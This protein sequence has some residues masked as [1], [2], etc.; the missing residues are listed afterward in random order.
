M[1]SIYLSKTNEM[2]KGVYRL[3]KKGFELCYHAAQAA[4]MFSGTYIRKFFV[5][6]ARSCK[7]FATKFANCGFDPKRVLALS[8]TFE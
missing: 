2:K 7:L 3:S 1:L 6:Q 4:E 8:S 5:L